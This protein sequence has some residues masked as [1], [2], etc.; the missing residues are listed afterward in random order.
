MLLFVTLKI[1][2][3]K[4][5]SFYIS[6]CKNA[7]SISVIYIVS[8]ILYIIKVTFLHLSILATS[9]FNLSLTRFF[10]LVCVRL[11]AFAPFLKAGNLLIFLT[12]LLTKSVLAFKK[13]LVFAKSL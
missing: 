8:S 11:K 7:N 1:K 9:T 5:S 6:A 3:I 2:F 10:F 4:S 12:R 13:L